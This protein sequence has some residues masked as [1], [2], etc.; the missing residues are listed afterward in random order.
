MGDMRELF[1]DLKELRRRDRATRAT[2]AAAMIQLVRDNSDSV[3]I[4]ANGTWNVKKGSHRIQFYPTK[5][6]WQYR[7]KMFRGGIYAFVNWLEKIS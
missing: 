7:N 4:D 2:Q 1:D 3:N 6:T 5:G